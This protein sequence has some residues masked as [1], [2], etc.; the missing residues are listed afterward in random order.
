MIQVMALCTFPKCS[1]TLLRNL[2]KMQM[3]SRNALLLDQFDTLQRMEK[4]KSW[5]LWMS[6]T[7]WEICC[8]FLQPFIYTFFRAMSKNSLATLWV[9]L[10]TTTSNFL[11][12]TLGRILIVRTSQ[13]LKHEFR[14][15]L[16]TKHLPLVPKHLKSVTQ[17]RTS[18]TLFFLFTHFTKMR[19]HTL[20]ALTVCPLWTKAIATT[21]LSHL[22]TVWEK[23]L[24]WV[25]LHCKCATLY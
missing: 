9:S 13:N 3:W 22:E 16:Q 20:S 21:L 11:A 24:R 4:L 2:L 23:L 17:T 25:A 5:I 8:F 10:V 12:R 6:S 1:L 19:K 18:K 7:D 15:L 14:T